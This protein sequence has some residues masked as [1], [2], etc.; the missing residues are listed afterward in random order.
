MVKVSRQHKSETLGAHI[1]VRHHLIRSEDLLAGFGQL[2]LLVELRK[3]ASDY[4]TGEIF[5]FEG[6]ITKSFGAFGVVGGG[7]PYRRPRY[8]RFGSLADI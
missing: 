5:N 8:V 2:R 4:L 3:S 1:A 6:S 7:Y